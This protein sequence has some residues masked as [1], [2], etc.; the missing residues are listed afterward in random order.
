MHYNRS[1]WT[2]EE[3]MSKQ[4][5]CDCGELFEVT[6]DSDKPASGK[7]SGC[8]SELAPFDPMSKLNTPGLEDIF[9]W[10]KG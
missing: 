10:D 1:R 5:C 4:E 7:C 2:K 6:V 9:N 8:E 3:V